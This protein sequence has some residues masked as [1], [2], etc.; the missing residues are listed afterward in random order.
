VSV[1]PEEL[2][3]QQRLRWLARLH[4]FS[5]AGVAGLALIGA[6]RIP[7]LAIVPLLAIIIVMAGCEAALLA[8]VARHEGE[9]APPESTRIGLIYGQVVLDIIGLTVALHFSGGSENPFFPFYVFPVLLAGALLT[10]RATFGFA[11]LAT[12]LY[13]GLLIA[14]ALGWLPHYTLTGLQDPVAYQRW[15][16][17]AG[18]VL[19]L[20][21]TC[22]VTAEATSVL[23]EAL[24][25]RARQLTESHERLAARA[26][27]L[28]GLNE[29][30]RAANEDYKHSRE[31]MDD[32]YV[33]LQQAYTRL[34]IRS[35]NMSE[36]NEQL[37]QANAECKAR[38][39]ELSTVY[40]QMQEAYRRLETRSEHMRELN[41]QLRVANA[42]CSRQRNELAKL[43]GQLVQANDKLSALED[44][45]A[46]FTLLVTHE[47]RAP[48][49][50]IQ[51]YLKLILEGYV[52]PTKVQET[53]EK[54][55]KRAM[56]QLAL[57]ADLLELGRIQSADA[58]GKVEPIQLG[59][60]LLEQ[61]DLMAARAQERGITIHADVDPELPLVLSNNDQIR[62]VW[63]NLI[64]NAIKY[65]RDDGRVDIKLHCEGDRIVGSVSDTGIG[66][67]AEAMTRLFSEFFRADNAK[68]A[69]RMGTGLGLSIVKEIIEHSGGQI[70]CESEIDKGTTFR[71][72]LPV[73]AE[74]V[75]EEAIAVE[76]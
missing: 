29:Q 21:A 44:A 57:I 33:E 38:R 31:H 42:Q 65:N 19:S 6:W 59:R 55:E 20:G 75:A 9:H 10:R 54:A 62:S 28:S 35:R 14:E 34:E 25:A 8:Y 15:T 26:A 56:E 24:R 16:Y 45:R 1:A 36:L 30:L 69:S 22:F 70:T 5:L 73:I 71:F 27:E 76:S 12:V 49:A 32:L 39:E 51:S 48:V 7:G 68:A 50:A 60:A 74:P 67:P 41:E 61:M 23:M 58:R 2:L 64:S 52:P 72:W 4:L 66:I 46:Q 47:L 40:E 37:R 13:T 18:L 11:A 43:N 63:N 3:P 17:L 53:L